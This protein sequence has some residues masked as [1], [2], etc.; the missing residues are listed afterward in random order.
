M[1]KYKNCTQNIQSIYF[2]ADSAVGGGGA[3]FHHLHTS[4]ATPRHVATSEFYDDEE[5][6]SP[7]GGIEIGA[8]GGKMMANLRRHRQRERETYEDEDV[9]SSSDESSGRPIPRYV[10]RDTDHVFGEF[11]MDDED[12]VMRR[13]D[14]YGEDE[15]DEDYFDE[16]EP[17]A[18]LLP[19]GGG[20]RRVPRT[21][22]R[23][24]SSKC[25]FFGE[26]F[27][28]FPTTVRDTVLF[29]SCLFV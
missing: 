18:E 27:V 24:N 1:H 19:L 15:T 11:E 21:P 23:K 2:F 7:R 8:G 17:V 14:G 6:T 5:A 12:V 13:E 28:C 29:N 10:G 26:G 3:A 4:A 25:G 9:L 20:T 22:G 16:E